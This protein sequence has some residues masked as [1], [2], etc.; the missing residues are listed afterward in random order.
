MKASQLARGYLATKTVELPLCR[1]TGT[2]GA[3]G[4]APVVTVGLRPL[5]PGEEGQ[6]YA[7]ALSYARAL[8]VPDAKDG[9]ELVEY[10]KALHRC[11][12]GAV[13]ADSPRGRPEPF[14]DGGLEQLERMVEIG[15]DGVLTLAEMHQAYTD[16]VAGLTAE[17][18]NEDGNAFERALE[19]LAGP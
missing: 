4:A 1:P 3:P 17:L 14:F 9:D 6:V 12:L 2:D 15:K 10:G 8:G 5:E 11:L 18:A 16:E 19:E 7:R 13:D